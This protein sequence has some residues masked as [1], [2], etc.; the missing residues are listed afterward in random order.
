[1]LDTAD[2]RRD[3]TN[4]ETKR[5]VD[6][7]AYFERIGYRGDRAPTLANLRAIHALHPQ[8]IAFENLDP[9]LGRPVRLDM[10][11]IET[12]LVLGGR[13]GYCYEHNLLFSRVLQALGFRVAGLMARVLWNMP[14]P[15]RA[16]RS[17][18]LLRVD[19]GGEDYLADVGFG[20]QVLTGPLRFEPGLEQA[21]PHE[22]FRVMPAGGDFIM[23]TK[24]GEAWAPLYRFD[25]QEQVLAD[26]E[27]ANWYVPRIRARSSAPACSWRGLR[28]AGAIRCSAPTSRR[29]TGMA[30]PR[31]AS[32]GA[33]PSC[34]SC[35]APSSSSHLR[36]RPSSTP[37]WRA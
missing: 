27:I 10:A 15:D 2:T 35:S 1:M 17:H 32:C 3:A 26:Y 34:A 16:P 6:L 14:E 18:M 22:P 28:G 36:P 8:A 24:I 12:K 31:S 9:L 5:A 30:A 37:F 13:G 4:A 23:Q 19:V 33:F 7:D 20:G 29:T 25:R 21:T 11:S